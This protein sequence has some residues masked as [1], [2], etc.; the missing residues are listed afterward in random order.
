MPSTGMY[1]RLGLLAV[2]VVA[3]IS[4][5]AHAQLIQQYFPTNIP[6]YSTD[7]SPSVI[8]RMNLQEQAEGVEY[9]DFVFRPNLSENFG[10]NSS[11]LGA[12]NSASS[13][14]ETNASLRVNSDWTRNSIGASFN[15]DNQ[16][17]FALPFANF[18]NW[19]A[20][21]GGSL[22]VGN[23]T[24]TIAYSHL[25]LH[26][27]ATELGVS[28]IVAPVPYG[29]DD[30]R[31]SYTKLFS[32]FSVTPSFEF[33]NFSF[34]QAGEPLPV[35]YDS[36]NHHVESGGVTTRYEFSPGNAAEGT[37]R[38]SEANFSLE[39]SSNYSDIQIFGGLDFSGDGVIRYRT[40]F[41]FEI[42]KFPNGTTQTLTTP[43]F[44]L[45]V[46]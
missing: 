8:D 31:L 1:W 37:I 42:R 36:L 6:G 27:T 17:F 13:V 7:F 9:G 40:L 18:T 35:N 22:L 32:R 43:T 29:V 26:L 12:P 14:M 16:R 19:N 39:P 4:G 46:V 33:E 21:L 23:D 24:M 44:E 34:G 30:A 41:G 38:V 25:N 11:A 5:N 20:G 10:Y 3:S 28:G 15:V 2:G 45:D